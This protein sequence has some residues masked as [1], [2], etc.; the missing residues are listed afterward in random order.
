MSQK[1]TFA[2]LN[3]SNE[4]D[5]KRMV[6]ITIAFIY[7]WIFARVVGDSDKQGFT[8]NIIKNNE[9]ETCVPTMIDDLAKLLPS[10]RID[11]DNSIL[12]FQIIMG[13]KNHGIT[14]AYA[15]HVYDHMLKIQR[16]KQIFEENIFLKELAAMHPNPSPETKEEVNEND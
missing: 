13:Y 12:I 6:A 10:D 4:Y 3:D 7:E 9:L 1:A 16:F 2:I 11:N 8:L 5:T 15:V 14:K